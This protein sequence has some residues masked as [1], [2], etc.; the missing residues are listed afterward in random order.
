MIKAL[1]AGSKT[2][3]RRLVKPQPDTSDGWVRWGSKR[4]DNGDGVHQFHTDDASA[5]RLMIPACPYGMPGDRLWVK[6]TWRPVELNGKR[7]GSGD[8]MYYVD[9]AADGAS[10]GFEDT[11]VGD[12]Q[13]PK[14]AARGN[15]TPLFMPRWASRILLEVTEVRV[16]RLN[17][18]S[19]EDAKAEGVTPFEHDPEGDCW[20]AR[21]RG[22]MYRSAFEYLWG[23]INGWDGEPGARAPWPT[24]PFVW[25]VAFRRLEPKAVV[26]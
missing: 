2:Q 5:R 12:W 10:R 15:V 21:P 17:D 23:E 13:M 14:A 7:D 26:A 20:T 1:L 24:N 22:E 19:E 18:I 11:E 25:V 9:Y 3:T 6:E 4:Y 16:E 8:G